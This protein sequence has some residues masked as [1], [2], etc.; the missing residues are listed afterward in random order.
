LQPKIA[1]ESM[2]CL[3]RNFASSLA[4]HSMPKNTLYL[5]PYFASALTSPITLEIFLSLVLDLAF[6]LVPY[7]TSI[8]VPPVAS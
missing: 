8:L 3:V 4:P 6:G 5:V 7:L 2:P 1:L